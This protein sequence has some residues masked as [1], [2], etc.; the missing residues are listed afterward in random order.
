MKQLTPS[1][2]PR[3][4]FYHRTGSSVYRK[5]LEMCH[6]TTFDIGNPP[7]YAWK[8]KLFGNDV[9][10]IKY[11]RTDVE[12]DIDMIRETLGVKHGMI[13]WIPYSLTEV[14]K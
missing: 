8:K 7:Q 11:E 6:L 4:F 10:V 14:P 12:P 5:Y 3:D 9:V 13:S 1:E 2:Y